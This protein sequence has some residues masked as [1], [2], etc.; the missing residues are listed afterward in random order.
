MNLDKLIPTTLNAALAAYAIF[1]KATQEA[2]RANDYG[3][4][5]PFTDA[6]IH[7][8]Q[9]DH[10][11]FGNK[12]I[13]ACYVA[14]IED[15]VIWAFRGTLSDFNILDGGGF[16]STLR[17]WLNDGEAS[18]V[19]FEHLPGKV[20][21]GFRNSLERLDRKACIDDVLSRIKDT[22]KKLIITG[23]SKGGGIVPIASMLLVKKYG[24]AAE[25]IHPILFEPARAGDVDFVNAF[26]QTFST[27]TN[28]AI[29]FEYQDD[30][31][32]HMPPSTA[33]I[34]LFKEVFALR[35]IED[36][37]EFF[38]G[39]DH[40]NYASVGTLKFIDWNDQIKTYTPEDPQ[41]PLLKERMKS[42][43]NV[44]NKE[45]KQ[46]LCDHVACHGKGCDTNKAYFY[47]VITGESC[48]KAE[49]ES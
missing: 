24:I 13:D 48:P 12:Y 21:E 3:Q 32:P 37:L 44:L 26:N 18:P 11:L 35:L 4:K 34:P 29:R 39:L 25:K 17:D 30:I 43:V 40:W 27:D 10:P 23:H 2:I 36:F 31:V 16:I 45:P 28:P 1:D 8:Y 38:D 49:L 9:A 22:N 20:H 14:E 42:L 7:I 15:A 41:G 33:E 19:S 47:K 46:A 5:V 6:P